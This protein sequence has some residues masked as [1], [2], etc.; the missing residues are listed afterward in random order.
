MVIGNHLFSPTELRHALYSDSVVFSAASNCLSLRWD[1][2]D[3]L[4]IR[5]DGST[6]DMDHI[7]RQKQQI[8]DIKISYENIFIE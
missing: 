4:I 8:G 3:R 7:N 5:C 6:V 2:Q 1:G